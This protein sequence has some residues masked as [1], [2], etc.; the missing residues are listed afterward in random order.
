MYELTRPSPK[1]ESASGA[2]NIVASLGGPSRR[3]RATGAGT[4]TVKRS[5]GTNVP[6]PFND[7]ESHDIVA[8]EI[9]SLSGVTAVFIQV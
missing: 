8:T 9:V 1:Y 7:G 2:Y 6:V 4:V 5:D 3:L